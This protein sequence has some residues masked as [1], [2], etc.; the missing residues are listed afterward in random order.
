VEKL[1]CELHNPGSSTSY[2]PQP[3]VPAPAVADLVP[4]ELLRREALGLPE[5]P[6]PAVVRHYTRLSSLNYHVDRGMYPLGSC[7]MKYNPK[8]NEEMAGLQGF[9]GL[10]PHLPE[11]ECR[12]ALEIMWALEGYLKEVSGMDRVSLQPAAGA[13]GELT[14][15]M[16]IR[17]F[18]ASRGEDRDKI[19]I[20][21]SAHGT[22]PASAALSGCGALTIPSGP[23]GRVDLEAMRKGLDARCAA[24]MITNPNTLGLFET[25]VK[26]LADMTHEAGALMYLDGANLNAVVGLA[27]PREMGFDVVHFNL[28]KTFS[29]PHGGGGP[30]SGPVGVVR[31]LEPFLPVPV[32]ERADDG[33]L[34][35]DFERPQSIGSVHAFYGNFGVMVRAYCYIRSLGA[36]GLEEVSR[37]AVLNANYLLARLKDCYELPYDS[38]CMHEFV[39]S[40]ISQKAK[41]VRT[42]DIGKRLLDYGLHAP[43]VYFPLIVPEAL[44]IEPTETEGKPEL[45]RFVQAMRRIAKEVE[46]EPETVKGA[47]YSTP[48]RRLDEALAARQLKVRWDGIGNGDP[49]ET[50]ER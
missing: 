10:H 21:D 8:V 41:G 42:A 45:D 36:E 19:L 2:L 50:I 15:L 30:G 14:G 7:T 43:T 49:S 31:E 27:R 13:Q 4:Q 39:L 32:L 18:H 38:R 26:K 28:H 48:V 25:D 24:V 44:M 35:W 29:S 16:M 3:D 20:P 17:A 12:G 22:N 6:E 33:P 5:A 40:G 23:D 46:E 9:A 1:L 11:E 37:R 47:P 34:F